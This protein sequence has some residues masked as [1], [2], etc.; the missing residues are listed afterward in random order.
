MD[1]L[2][3]YI[4]SVIAAAV[5]AAMLNKLFSES[6]IHRLIKTVSGLVLSVVLL[7]PLGNLS[8]SSY[9]SYFDAVDNDAKEAVAYGEDIYRD[10]LRA[11]I[12]ERCETYILDK[13]DQLGAVISV[14]I[15]CDSADIPI[16]V[17]AEI[18]GSV[19]P[20]IRKTLQNMIADDIGIPEENQLWM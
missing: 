11:I 12:S 18:S 10:N 4:V 17:Y 13:A 9:T 14:S 16:P 3:Q 15:R 8:I 1:H 19:S 2:R 20:Y 7:S 5:I 6:H